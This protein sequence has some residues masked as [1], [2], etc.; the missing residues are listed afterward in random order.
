MAGE[1]QDV[2]VNL[3]SK[4]DTSGFDRFIGK[5]DELAAAKGR[6][7]RE[8]ELFVD[9]ER[10]IRANLSE[11]VLGLGESKSAVEAASLSLAHLSEVFEVGFAGSVIGGVGAAV[12]SMV[13]K[14]KEEFKTLGDQIEKDEEKAHSLTQSLNGIKE[15]DTEKSQNQI[16]ALAASYQAANDKITKMGFLDRV[17]KGTAMGIGDF[18]GAIFG[19]EGGSEEFLHDMAENLALAKR[20]QAAQNALNDPTA[21]NQ[22]KRRE[23]A[24]KQ[25]EEDKKTLGE[26][27]KLKQEALDREHELQFD[28]MHNPQKEEDLKQRMAILEAV[29][30]SDLG[31]DT[32]GGEKRAA[33]NRLKII[34]LQKELN[35]LQKQDADDKE[36]AA[37]AA[38]KEREAREKQLAKEKAAE[39]DEDTEEEPTKEILG[40]RFRL[41]SKAGSQRALGGGGGA[42]SVLMAD[43]VVTESRKQTGLLTEINSTLKAG[44]NRGA[45]VAT[46]A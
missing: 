40:Y 4:A 18:G 7:R 15:T 1:E 12:I 23:D 25:L 24:K 28:Q 6:S 33:E 38:E 9:S 30:Q 46:F 13:S 32:P 34:G 31:E 43:P 41:E 14:T 45:P 21:R 11:L 42:Y 3:G 36:R 5:T 22:A 29:R 27:D 10:K 20:I 16:N 44:L 19:T 17:F 39:G 26:V 8:N 37:A 35:A 2:K